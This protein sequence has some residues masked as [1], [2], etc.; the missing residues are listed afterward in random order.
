MLGFRGASRYYDPRYAEGFAL[1]CAAIACVRNQMGLNNVIVMIPFCRTVEEAK[2]VLATMADY[3]LRQHENGLLVYAMCEIPSNVLL[4]RDFLA[5]FDGYSIG[6][7]DLTQ[8]TLGLDRDSA[9][10]AHLFDERNP[11][12]KALI[13]QAITAAHEAHKPIGICG[14]APSDYPEFA[15]WLVECG[16]T[17]ISLNPD[18]AIQTRIRIAD[19]EASMTVAVNA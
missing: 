15:A 7:N 4:A 5:I 2:R 12:V 3:G 9:T 17:S 6:S 10:V 14:Q 11:A 8:L 19:C 16:I 13:A 1:E 18:T